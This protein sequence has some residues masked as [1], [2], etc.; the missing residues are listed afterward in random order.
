MKKLLL[1]LLIVAGLSNVNAQTA[2][3]FTCN[4]CSGTSH[5]LFSECDAGNVVVLCWVM[6][7]GACVSGALTCSNVC[8]SFGS[9]VSFYLCDDV[10]NTNCTSLGSWATTN[11]INPTAK[12]SNSSINMSDYGSTGMPKAVVIGGPN[13]T[14]FYNANNTFNSTAMQAAINQALTATGIKEQNLNISSISVFPSPARETVTIKFNATKSSEVSIEVFDLQGKMVENVYNGTS[15]AGENIQSIN[16]QA[17]PAGMY[18]VKLTDGGK[19]QYAN[20]VVSH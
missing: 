1:S 16:V 2:T 10:G 8:A 17:Y 14:V 20:I 18:L 12:F 6:P 15:S 19:S 3:N 9:N 11:N 13:Y 5:T 7:C 4:D